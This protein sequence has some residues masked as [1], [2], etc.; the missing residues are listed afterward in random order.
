M[1]LFGHRSYFDDFIG[2]NQLKPT[3][4]TGLMPQ[5]FFNAPRLAQP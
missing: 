4:L 2:S 1:A 3:A 5:G